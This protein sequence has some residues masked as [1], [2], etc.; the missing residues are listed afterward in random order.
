[1]EHL[2]SDPNQAFRYITGGHGTFT[3][4]G[5]NARYTYST[6]Q[7]AD[8]KGNLSP[9]FIRV[10]TGPDNDAYIGY[11][12]LTNLASLQAGKKGLPGAQSYQALEWWLK[13]FMAK[14]PKI[15]DA[16]VW[17][18]G[19]CC[20]CGRQLTV[21]ESIASGIGPVCAEKV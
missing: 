5:K 20:R 1:M 12:P 17:H 21:P 14:S 18:E 19:T 4:V 3:L 15:T 9:I 8:D 16:Q 11:L 2:F 7:S 6:S 13:S 10:K